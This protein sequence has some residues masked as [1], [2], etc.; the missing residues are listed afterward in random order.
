MKFS[1]IKK[2]IQTPPAAQ[3]LVRLIDI[4]DELKTTMNVANFALSIPSFNYLSGT[5]MCIDRVRMRLD[6]DTA[7]AA[8][9]RSGAPAGRSHN[10]DFVKAFFE[11]D[12]TRGYSDQRH[13]D[14]YH[15]QY[16][17]SRD[18]NVPTVPTFTIIENGKQV[19]VVLCGWKD[20]R[21]EESQL[22]MWITM[23]ESGLFSYGDYRHSPSEVLIF[24][25]DEK[26]MRQPL[27]IERGDIECFSD[28][29]MRE[30]VAMYARAQE[31]AMPIAEAKW[32]DREQVRKQKERETYDPSAAVDEPNTNQPDFFA[33]DSGS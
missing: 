6:E 3:N 5:K 18:I 13:I 19:P 7:L 10:S 9:E 29:E 22:K 1:S 25:E 26:L 27:L 2:K 11:Y 12:R 15:G 24:P 33:K 20:L 28:T 4:N 16:R 21:L 32:Y 14:S 8:V 30:I 31:A 17:V 23:L